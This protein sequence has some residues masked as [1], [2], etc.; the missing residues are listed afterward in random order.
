MKN[1]FRQSDWPKE[2]GP[3]GRSKLRDFESIPGNRNDYP[4]PELRLAIKAKTFNSADYNGCQLGRIYMWLQSLQTDENR[5]ANSPPPLPL[6]GFLFAGRAHGAKHALQR[7]AVSS[8][9][10]SIIFPS[11][12]QKQDHVAR[13]GG[14]EYLGNVNSGPYY[15]E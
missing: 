6:A 13:R 9:V 8:A 2:T 4:S 1:I 15:Q 7:T 14:P 11:G 10:Q 5:T 3:L 12:N